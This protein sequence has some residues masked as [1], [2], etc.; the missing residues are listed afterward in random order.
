MTYGIDHRLGWRD[1]LRQLSGALPLGLLV[2]DPPMNRPDTYAEVAQAVGLKL[3]SGCDAVATSPGRGLRNSHV[4]GWAAYGVVHW[5]ERRVTK[6][7][8]R[9][10]LLLAAGQRAYNYRNESPAQ[11]LWTANIWANRQ[12][13]ELYHIRFPGSATQNDRAAARWRISRGDRVTSIARRWANHKEAK[14]A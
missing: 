4:S 2:F 1:Q 8:L 12:A 14:R 3:C 6:P 9:N 10:F 5:K 7:G 13:K 11:Q